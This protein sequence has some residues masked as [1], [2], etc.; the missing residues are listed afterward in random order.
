MEKIPLVLVPGLLCDDALWRLQIEGLSDVAESTVGNTLQDASISD[1]AERILTA[2][3]DRFALAGL[4]MGGY[5]CMEIMCR[6]PERVERLA[7][8][9]TTARADSVEQYKRRK[10]LIELAKIGKFRG[11][12]P[13]LLPLLVHARRQ[14]DTA[15]TLCIVEMASR[16]GQQGFLR[17]QTAIMT[18]RAQ[19]KGMKTYNLP[20]MILC[21]R[22]DML[23]PLEL[24]EEMA[25][26]IPA[27]RLCI[28]ED[29]GHLS[30][31]EQPN[32]V[33]ALLRDWLLR[34]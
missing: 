19:L 32:V 15:L 12:T 11:V 4:S 6:A 33:T 5:V 3:P 30:T 13:R 27:A 23:T 26:A 8:L 24:H 16:V 22:D 14:N 31:L 18:R 2:A 17:Q 34:D 21:G 29:C 9:D 7:L 25:N 10:G 20:V 28:V 1:M